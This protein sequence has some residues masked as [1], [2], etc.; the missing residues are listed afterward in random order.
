MFGLFDEV[1]LFYGIIA[2]FPD[3]AKIN[4]IHLN[5]FIP[6]FSISLDFYMRCNSFRVHIIKKEKEGN[7]IIGV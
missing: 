5:G 7:I 1:K 3:P 2:K 6:N 4:F